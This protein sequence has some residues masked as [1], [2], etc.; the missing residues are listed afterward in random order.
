[1]KPGFI[2]RPQNQRKLASS[3]VS[4]INLIQKKPKLPTP[5]EKLWQLCFR[6]RKGFYWCVICRKVPQSIPGHTMIFL[7][8]WKRLF[9]ENN[10]N[11]KQKKSFSTTITIELIAQLRQ[12][13]YSLSSTTIQLIRPTYPSVTFSYSTIW[14]KKPRG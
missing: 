10:P 6:M 13:K 3:G 2:T 7:R 5:P 9:I 1:M 14:K 8:T 11:W 4:Q 12:W